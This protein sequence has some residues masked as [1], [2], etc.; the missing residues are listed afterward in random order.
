MGIIGILPVMDYL[1]SVKISKSFLI[2][3]QLILQD[4]LS[5]GNLTKL[6]FEIT[7]LFFLGFSLPLS[8]ITCH[9]G[10]FF[11]SLMCARIWKLSLNRQDCEKEKNREYFSHRFALFL[12]WI[13]EISLSNDHRGIRALSLCPMS[14]YQ[15]Y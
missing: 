4:L 14:F 10:Q 13:G 8:P 12:Y 3:G 7:D 5:P 9:N 1:V 6:L 11:R 15:N 2:P